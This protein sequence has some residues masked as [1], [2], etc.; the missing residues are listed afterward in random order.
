MLAAPLL[1]VALAGVGLWAGGAGPFGKRVPGTIYLVVIDPNKP[2]TASPLPSGSI[3]ISFG[4]SATTSEAATGTATATATATVFHPTP[5]RPKPNLVL[6]S[7]SP[8]NATC[9]VP[10]TLTSTIRNVGPVAAGPANVYIA[11]YY[12]DP[13]HHSVAHNYAN[14]AGLGPGE[15]VTVPVTLT[16]SQGCDKVHELLIRLDAAEHVDESDEED[17]YNRHTHTLRAPNLYLSDLTI[18]A[19]PPCSGVNVGVRINNNGPVGTRRDAL[20]KFTDTVGGHPS[21]TR[22]VYASFPLIPAGTSRIVN[23]TFSALTSYCDYLHT[24]TA[25]V[26]SSG[27]IGESSETDNSMARTFVPH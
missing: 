7:H 8:L 3:E 23:V 21:F 27:V 19:D 1:I 10:F 22:S 14:Y 5:T 13:D 12:Y 9:E 6:V 25:V 15:T 11:D 26:D 2:R 24:M 18:P 16:I 20:I 4:P 17:N